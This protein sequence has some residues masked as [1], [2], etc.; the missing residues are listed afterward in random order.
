MK[1]VSLV[2]FQIFVMQGNVTASETFRSFVFTNLASSSILLDEN[3]MST[4]AHTH[5][6]TVLSPSLPGC[7]PQRAIASWEELSIHPPSHPMDPQS[8]LAFVALPL[9]P[10]RMA[11]GQGRAIFFSPCN[12]WSVVIS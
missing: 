4:V 8:A 3:N 6:H 1:L 12:L 2:Y 9:F 5:T 11:V 10:C 7:N